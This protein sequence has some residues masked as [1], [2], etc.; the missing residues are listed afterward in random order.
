MPSLRFDSR[1]DFELAFPRL[2]A[3]SEKPTYI[4]VEGLMEFILTP[5][6]EAEHGT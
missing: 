2:I 4:L 3:E 5:V 1:M 6:K